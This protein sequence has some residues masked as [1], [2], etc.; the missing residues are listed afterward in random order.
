MDMGAPCQTVDKKL[1]IFKSIIRTAF[2]YKVDA[3][4]TEWLGLRFYFT[5]ILFSIAVTRCQGSQS[6]Q[7]PVIA[8]SKARW[9]HGFL[10]DPAVTGKDWS[11]P[12]AH[13][14]GHRVL[15]N[16]MAEGAKGDGKTDDTEAFHQAWTKACKTHSAV[17]YVPPGTKLFVKPR[18]FSGPCAS[19][20]VL[21][22]DGTILSLDEPDSWRKTKIWLEFE[23]LQ[24]FSMLG[25]G[26]INGR[27]ERWWAQACRPTMKQP[28]MKPSLTL[29]GLQAIV[30]QNCKNIRVSNLRIRD[31]QKFHLAFINCIGVR[32]TRLHITAP[33]SSPNTDGIHIASSHNVSILNCRI[34]T[35]D[36]C[37]SIQTGSSMLLI[38]D[39]KC[40]PGHGIS[41][42]SLGKDQKASVWGVIVN[43]VY[44]DHTTNGFRIKTWQGGSG[45]AH[46]MKFMNAKMNSVSKPI[47]IDQYYCD[48]PNGCANE[49]SAVEI[50]EII[51]AN[52]TGTSATNMAVDI[53]C[54]DHVPCTNIV[55]NN[56]SLR[57]LSDH[58]KAAKFS[59]WEVY[60]FVLGVNNP[61]S[62]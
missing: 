57:S 51:F 29:W 56:L 40:G 6:L 58:K 25:R 12:S 53:Q 32:A 17:V 27:G 3:S 33:A 11:P 41:I 1:E 18:K 10:L 9:D 39:I 31:S 50:S 35:G 55:L 36:D 15:F 14:L 2:N 48:S 37:I 42:G 34:Q 5:V 44:F 62:C 16:V 61:M 19:K 24:N 21:K 26:D 54:S 38:Q 20:L 4:S 23:G 28:E 7:F 30:F 47:A 8:M 60:G 52:I 45:H 59:C 46:G 43:R 13:P 22:V 49:T